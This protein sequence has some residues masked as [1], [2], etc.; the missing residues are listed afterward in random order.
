MDR[1]SDYL[2][3][4]ALLATQAPALPAPARRWLETR[5]LRHGYHPELHNVGGV[6]C[7]HPH[8]HGEDDRCAVVNGRALRRFETVK[9]GAG[10]LVATALRAAAHPQRPAP[11]LP[12]TL[13]GFRSTHPELGA[14]QPEFGLLWEL[15]AGPPD[16]ER[17]FRELAAD[18]EAFERA[19]VTPSPTDQ[20]LKHL[21]ED[22]RAWRAFRD[23]WKTGS[24]DVT[25]LTAQEAAANRIRSELFELSK[26]PRFGRDKN[27]RGGDIEDATAALRAAAAIDKTSRELERTAGDWWQDLWGK[28]PW[29]AKAG[30]GA[31]GALW[32]LATL[33]DI[34]RWR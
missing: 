15:F 33:R 14:V 10:V 16:G 12:A 7:A 29:Q 23:A 1:V 27:R 22:A 8:R 11:D 24:P 30:A 26:D 17:R 9:Q 2:V 32:V 13:D 25:A 4:E 21:A 18:W 20:R 34:T 31:L 6:L 28:V 19:G 5:V 3:R